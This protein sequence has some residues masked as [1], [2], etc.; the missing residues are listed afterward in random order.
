VRVEHGADR[1]ADFSRATQ[2]LARAG[3]SGG[4]AGEVTHGGG[5]Q[6]LALAGTLG[7]ESAVAADDEPLA[8]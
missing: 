1:K 5:E 4:D 2:R 3:N 8:G 6:I 7:G